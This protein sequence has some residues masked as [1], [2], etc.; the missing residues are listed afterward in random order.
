MD[1]LID[2]VYPPT[3]RKPVLAV[4]ACQTARSL[5]PANPGA[6]HSRART[7]MALGEGLAGSARPLAEIVPLEG[8]FG[9]MRVHTVRSILIEWSLSATPLGC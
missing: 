2:Q 9:A 4:V 3:H 7:A 5:A 1:D 6:N 8:I